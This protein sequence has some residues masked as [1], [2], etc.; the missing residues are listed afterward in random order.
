MADFRE[1]FDRGSSRSIS[2]ADRIRFL[3]D[4]ERLRNRSEET[5]EKTRFLKW[6]WRWRRKF[7]QTSKPRNREMML[8]FFLN[9]KNE[10][11]P[12]KFM[13]IFDGNMIVWK[14]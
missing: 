1:D 5:E 3:E 4:R 6:P 7:S 14:N 12:P 2:L 13:P 11:E 8:V 9:K 10:I